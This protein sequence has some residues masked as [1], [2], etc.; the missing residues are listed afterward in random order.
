MP[1]RAKMRAKMYAQTLV[2]AFKLIAHFLRATAAHDL[3]YN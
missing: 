3:I 1:M 2:L